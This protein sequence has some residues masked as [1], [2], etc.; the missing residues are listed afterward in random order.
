MGEAVAKDLVGDTH[1]FAD[2]GRILVNQL[3]IAIEQAINR[4]IEQVRFSICGNQ[5]QRE[6]VDR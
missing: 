5:R 6:R 1:E 2:N 3:T 4:Q